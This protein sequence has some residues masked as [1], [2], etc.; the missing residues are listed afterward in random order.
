MACAMRSLVSA[1]CR[2]GG[3]AARM[4]A[5][6][7]AVPGQVAIELKAGN[8]RH[9]GFEKRLAFD[10]RQDDCF[11]SIEVEK[12]EGVIHQLHATRSVARRLRL[13]EARQPVLTDATQ[14]AI[15][16]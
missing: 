1:V 4:L 7:F 5:D 13:R 15:E 14:L 6:Q 3:R 9:P 2:S 12:I 8:A 10:Q 11:A 16:I